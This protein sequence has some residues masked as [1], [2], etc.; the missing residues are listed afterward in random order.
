MN[1][2]L[3]IALA[4]VVVAI[5]LGLIGL[6]ARALR[7]LLYLAIVVLIV[8]AAVQWLMNRGSGSHSS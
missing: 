5:A 3:K 1:R 6:I 2:P 7:W 8:A 4:L